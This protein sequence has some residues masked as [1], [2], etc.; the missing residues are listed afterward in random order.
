MIPTYVPLLKALKSEFLAVAEMA[1]DD[2]RKTLPLFEI[3]RIGKNILEAKR[4]EGC[5]EIKTAY[6]NEVMS[7][8]A[9]VWAGRIAMVDAYHWAADATIENGE[10]VI[11]YI[12][13][14]LNTL[15]VEVVPVI[16]Y[17]R[18][19]DESYS[20][21]LRSFDVPHDSNYC[22]RLDSTAIED[23]AEPDFF[24]ENIETILDDL[25]LDAGRCSVLID[26]GDV[27]NTSVEVLTAKATDIVDQLKSFGFKYFIT[28]GCSLPKTID[29]AVKKVDS[30]GFV[31][32][33][34]MQLWQT[35]R[36]SAPAT[37][38]IYGDYGV[39]GPNTNEGVRSKHTNG[40]IRY[41][42][43]KQFFVVRG[44]SMS[45]PGKG[46]QMY[47]LAETLVNSS[48]YMG[49]P[50]S[51]GDKRVADCSRKKIKGGAPQW[52]T[53]DTS[54]HLAYVVSEVEEFERSAVMAA[55]KPALN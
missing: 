42:I 7:G 26:F 44:H 16:G 1:R 6:L 17:D 21:A 10:H 20:L 50:F 19:E 41:T 43:D 46:E 5:T 39:R 4:F 31:L 25:R 51:W 12:Y 27:T 49:E 37:P 32:R 3:S 24:Q 22:L 54:H 11:P 34:E 9:S 38:I 23:S 33:R 30:V 28:S 35:L 40:K 2:A 53:I 14:T 29:A 13:S 55:T 48:H 36:Q 8:I 45:L 18:W 15:G 47:T 52:I